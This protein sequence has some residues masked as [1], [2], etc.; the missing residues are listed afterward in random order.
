[1][2]VGLSRDP[3]EGG[4]RE[5]LSLFKGIVFRGRCRGNVRWG[6]NHRFSGAGRRSRGSTARCPVRFGVI[7]AANSADWGGSAQTGSQTPAGLSRW[8][9]DDSGAAG[10]ASSAS[11]P[12]L[13]WQDGDD[14]QMALAADRAGVAVEGRGRFAILFGVLL[15]RGVDRRADFGQAPGAAAVGEPAEGP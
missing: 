15:R 11:G 10:L 4:K 8:R 12:S 14:P 5:R 3:A 2:S 1:M 7:V 9:L 13:R 6:K